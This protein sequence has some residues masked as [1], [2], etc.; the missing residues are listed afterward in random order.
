MRNLRANDFDKREPY[1]PR[2]LNKFG[3][4]A[5]LDQYHSMFAPYP[6]TDDGRYR[7]TGIS[8]RDASDINITHPDRPPFDTKPTHEEY[9]TIVPHE[10][11]RKLIDNLRQVSHSQYRQYF[12]TY[13]C[14]SYNANATKYTRVKSINITYMREDT[15]PN[16]KTAP[17]EAVDLG[18]WECE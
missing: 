16:Y 12:A 8:T 18:T 17:A 1:F 10:K 5:R 15:L 14:R 13:L 6:K 4:L 11:W 3:F 9:V 2:T 7:I